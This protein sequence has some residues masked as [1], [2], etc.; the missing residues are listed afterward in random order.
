MPQH[1]DVAEGFGSLA[2]DPE[3]PQALVDGVRRLLEHDEWQQ[4]SEKV[5]VLPASGPWR[6]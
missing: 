4:R 5:A 6:D 2:A 3:A 1:L